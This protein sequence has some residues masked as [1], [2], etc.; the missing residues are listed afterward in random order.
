VG[1]AGRVTGPRALPVTKVF[2]PLYASAVW[3]RAARMEGPANGVS[4]QPGVPRYPAPR[5]CPG[6]GATSDQNTCTSK[7]PLDGSGSP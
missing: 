4:I 5:K 2:R 1:H 7:S 3:T 6:Y